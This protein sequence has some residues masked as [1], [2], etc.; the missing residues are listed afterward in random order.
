MNQH[1][2]GSAYGVYHLA[3][4]DAAPVD[5]NALFVIDGKGIIYALS[6]SPARSITVN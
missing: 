6:I 5:S 1:P 2:T 4:Q 3:E